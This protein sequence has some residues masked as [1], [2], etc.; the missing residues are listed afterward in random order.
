M[1]LCRLRLLSQ[2][3]IGP[4]FSEVHDLLSYMGMLQA[5]DY[6]MMRYA[7][8]IRLRRPSMKAFRRAY[9]EGQIVRSHLFRCT[10]QLVA[11]EDLRWMNDLCAERNRRAIR[12]YLAAD[13]TRIAEEEYRDFNLA[14]ADI[15]STGPL[16]LTKDELTRRL[17]DGGLRPDRHRLTMF[18]RRAE[19]EGIVCS[20][21][22]DDRQATYSL[23]SR[24][25]PPAVPVGREEALKR[26]ARMYFRG[27]S[28]ATAEDFVWWTGLAAADCRQAIDSLRPELSTIEQDGRT[29]YL[30][31]DCAVKGG[32]MRTLLLPPYDE[33]LIGY[34][35]RDVVIR[36]EHQH[37][38]YTTYGIFYPIVVS[39]GRVVANWHPSSREATPFDPRQSFDIRPQI[40]AYH[41]F[42]G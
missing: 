28:P 31:A 5:Q 35:T 27:H 2:Q 23:I 6:K 13:G 21:T 33:Y 1:D 9:D 19:T 8:C 17:S 40:E 29:Y 12:S 24:R 34:K 36:P 3:L 25:L 42:F 18:L 26:L 20:G 37:R 38:A 10:W 41:R 7:A 30:H 4:R 14:V 11:A 32:R 15:L 22:L 39:Q 16:S